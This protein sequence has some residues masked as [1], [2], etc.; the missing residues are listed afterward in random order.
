MK[1]NIHTANDFYSI[2]YHDDCERMIV[3]VIAIAKN[4][5]DVYSFSFSYEN[6]Y[7]VH[8]DI[9]DVRKREDKES[10][11]FDD[12]MNEAIELLTMFSI[13]SPNFIQIW[14]D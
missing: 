8:M 11:S 14:L 4:N 6:L 3:H 7:R 9:N 12:N 2:H 1:H 13:S 10:R 5:V